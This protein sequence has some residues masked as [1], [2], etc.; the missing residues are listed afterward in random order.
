MK[1]TSK[2]IIK[3]RYYY[4]SVC[5]Y[6]KETGRKKQY[7]IK[8]SLV[9]DGSEKA[10]RLKE[11][12][13]RKVQ[14][15]KINGVNPHRIARH[16]FPWNAENGIG[17][18][19]KPMSL[20]EGHDFYQSKRNISDKSKSINYYSIKH[21]CSFLTDNKIIDEI[22]EL[23][24]EQYVKQ[25]QFNGRSNTSINMDLRNLRAMLRYLKTHK[26]IG[27]IPSFKIALKDAPVNDEDPIYI[28]EI[29]FAQI[30]DEDWM[31]LR[32][33]KRDFYKKVFQMYWDLGLRLTEPFK[34]EIV[35]KGDDIFLCP[36]ILKKGMQ[37][38]INISAEHALIIKEMQEL[39]SKKPTDDHIKNYSK[40]FKK[41]LRHCDIS[42][43]KHL[44]SLR[45]SYGIRRRI[46]TNGNVQQVQ[47]EMGHRTYKTTEKYQRRDITELK[48]D[49]PS[50]KKMI[51]SM[52]NDVNKVYSTTFTSTTLGSN[53]II[54]PP[55]MN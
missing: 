18:F 11:K 9:S 13:E 50:L 35:F 22:V 29:E 24:L 49:F 26:K 34:S 16:V 39:Y 52:E 20:I 21:I 17:G 10:M 42:E 46:E 45:H 31:L 1:K 23:D 19:V 7:P 44:H 36:P 51:E 33:P 43:V 14:E 32:T 54:S 5:V 37:R 55:E 48:H 3:G 2:L 53:S 41:A 15:F 27:N 40:V 6:N 30:M 4:K 25:M 28:S 8:L 38:K 47:A 12:V